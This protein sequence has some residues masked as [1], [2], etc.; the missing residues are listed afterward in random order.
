M[1]WWKQGDD[2]LGD[3][4]VDVLED[5][6]RDYVTDHPKPIWQEFLDSTHAALA[7]DTGQW[8]S[9]PDP[10]FNRRLRS[11][12]DPPAREFTSD[13]ARAGG[14]LTD[15][16]SETFAQIAEEYEER[17]GRKPTLSELLGTISFSLGVRTERFLT[18][19]SPDFSVSKIVAEPIS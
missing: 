16:L 17:R 9:D 8:L 11:Y 10:L 12:I 1:G 7:R 3:G 13:A 6:L 5:G 2:L 18:V 19:S 4:P 14:T 15:A